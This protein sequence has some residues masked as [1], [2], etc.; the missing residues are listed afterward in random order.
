MAKDMTGK[1]IRVGDTVS[2]Q[3]CGHSWADYRVSRVE[4]DRVFD[5]DGTY[6]HGSELLRATQTGPLMVRHV[7]DGHDVLLPADAKL[8]R[9]LSP[10]DKLDPKEPLSG[11]W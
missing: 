7:I 5:C 11:T 8:C 3:R 2:Y 9:P 4:G 1:E 6:L 10:N